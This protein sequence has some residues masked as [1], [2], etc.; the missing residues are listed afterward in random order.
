MSTC[1]KYELSQGADK[2]YPKIGDKIALEVA[3]AIK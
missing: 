3:F 1:Q 2:H